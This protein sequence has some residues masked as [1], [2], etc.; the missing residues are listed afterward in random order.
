[1]KTTLNYGVATAISAAM[2]MAATIDVVSAEQD[3]RYPPLPSQA[4]G[5]PAPAPKFAPMPQD[6]AAPKFAPARQ[7]PPAA[8]APQAAPAPA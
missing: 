1:M 2:V 5:Q 4:A 7:A 3:Y 8:A 6:P